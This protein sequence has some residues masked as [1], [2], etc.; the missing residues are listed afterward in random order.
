LHIILPFCLIFLIHHRDHVF[1]KFMENRLRN[2]TWNAFFWL[3]FVIVLFF[4]IVESILRPH[5]GFILFTLERET[6]CSSLKFY[7]L[8]DVLFWSSSL[9]TSML[10]E[11][12]Q[13]FFYFYFFFWQHEFRAMYL[14]AGSLPLEP[15]C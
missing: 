15:L 13:F 8:I 12:T 6:F 2:T 4:D 10:L 5:V 9:S 14:L 11:L 1:M 7:L 3:T